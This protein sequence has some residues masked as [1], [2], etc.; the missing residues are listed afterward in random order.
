MLSLTSVSVSRLMLSIRSLATGLQL[1]PVW[2]LS[3]AELSRVRWR[4]GSR[5]GELI[6]EVDEHDD[7]VVLDIGPMG[8]SS[9]QVHTP[10]QT[11]PSPSLPRVYTTVVGTY[12]DLH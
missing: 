6:V 11:Q 7:D 2:L 4:K 10:G 5:D 3:N 1:D 12:D 8:S 9:R